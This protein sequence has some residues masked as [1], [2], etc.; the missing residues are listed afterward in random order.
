[1]RT[2]NPRLSVSVNRKGVLDVDSVKGCFHGMNKYPNGG[3]YGLCYAA[4]MAKARGYDF[5]KSVSRL[6]HP[7]DTYR[8]AEIVD[9]HE[10][11]WFRVGTMGD[12]CHDWPLTVKI[13]E[14]LGKFKAPV[15]ITKHWIKI[16]DSL[17]GRLARINSVVNTSISPLDS[18]DEIEHRLQQ[19]FRVK[20]F[21]IKAVLRIVSAKF[22]DD[23]AR[24]EVQKRLFEI[25]PNIDNPLRIPNSD[26]R[27]LSGEISVM[28]RQ[29]INKQ[30]SIS[31]ANKTA[32]IGT[33]LNCPDQCGSQE[34]RGWRRR[35]WQLSLF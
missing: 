26:E 24:N 21:G 35:E 5:S 13:C 8:I 27:V 4:R 17:L 11:S 31:V 32:Y 7:D 6:I 25:V 18:E 28:N 23:D 33:C 1:M 15:I 10:S 3:C 9:R 14:W 12:P 30:S 16:D 22:Q 19:H 20:S 2:F 34:E 29:D